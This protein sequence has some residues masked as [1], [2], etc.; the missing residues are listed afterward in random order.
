MK[1]HTLTTASALALLIASPAFAE[2]AKINATAETNS[3]MSEDVSK[4]WESTKEN[5]SEA[6][7]KVAEETKEAYES[8][9]ATLVDKNYT[10]DNAQ[11][12]TIDSRN[13]ANGMIG[14]PIYNHK[15]EKIATVHDI[16]VDE[17]GRATQVIVADGGF[18]GLGAKYAAFD[19]SLVSQRKA[20]G[21][22]IMPLSEETIK[23]AAKFSYDQAD[24]NKDGVRVIPAGSYS[25]A[26]LLGGQLVNPANETV[27]QIDNI[28]FQNGAAN[29]VIVAFDQMLGLG[30]EK[31]V[32]A[33]D[34][35]KVVK[36]DETGNNIDFQLTAAEATQ[37]ETFKNAV[38]SN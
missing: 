4:A 26:T 28:S 5:V 20:D 2:N 36:Q 31:A 21:D 38:K 37:F 34:D 12:I 29:Q 25:V 3:T 1:L 13:T 32:V 10:A 30:G 17:K 8:I 19:Y 15:N 27:A 33:Y 9:K 24:A 16:I 18:L 35:V 22:V 6:A 23:K 11:T 7:G 14:Q